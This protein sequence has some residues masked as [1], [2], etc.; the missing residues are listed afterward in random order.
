MKEMSQR[1][2]VLERSRKADEAAA[3]VSETPST[4]EEVE[5]EETDEDDEEVSE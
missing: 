3:G 5:E 1:E 2:K 4:P